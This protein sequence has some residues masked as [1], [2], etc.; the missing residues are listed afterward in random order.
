MKAAVT[1]MIKVGC[2]RATAWG[3][4][5]SMRDSK[6]AVGYV[7]EHR[8]VLFYSSL[9]AIS[10]PNAKVVSSSLKMFPVFALLL[11]SAIF[12][13]ATPLQYQPDCLV[14]IHL[15]AGLSSSYFAKIVITRTIGQQLRMYLGLWTAL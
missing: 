6:Y 8:L 7:L 5:R 13:S 9:A 14:T 11:L 2:T 15:R 12:V 3:D 10:Q 1:E 4:A